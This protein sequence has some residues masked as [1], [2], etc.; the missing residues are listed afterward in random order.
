MGFLQT[1][2]SVSL[3]LSFFIQISSVSLTQCGHLFYKH[4]CTSIH[5]HTHTH[6][7]T[8][9]DTSTQSHRLTDLDTHTQGHTHTH[10]RTTTQSH[11]HTRIGC[12][13]TTAYAC[14]SE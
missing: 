5:T 4:N 13:M 6:T 10:T 1:S 8:H 7:H 3:C 2:V 11:T 12:R 14:V 9:K